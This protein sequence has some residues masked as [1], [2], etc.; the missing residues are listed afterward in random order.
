MPRRVPAT[1]LLKYTLVPPRWMMALFGFA[2]YTASNTR[3]SGAGGSTSDGVNDDG[4]P[5]VAE[6]GMLVS[7]EGNIGS[8]HRRVA[9][10]ISSHDQRKVRNISGGHAQVAAVAAG[11]V[12]A[13]SSGLA[14]RRPP[15]SFLMD[16][17]LML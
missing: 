12:P 2:D 8:D 7:A 13:R 3:R 10:S 6:N 5:A 11:A 14:P 15:L 4:G 1:L 16:L 17:Q 9:G